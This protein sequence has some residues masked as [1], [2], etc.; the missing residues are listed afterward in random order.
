MANVV[1]SSISS[2]M[3]AGTNCE[4]ISAGGA[5]KE[6]TEPRGRGT[7]YCIVCASIGMLT[8]GTGTRRPEPEDVF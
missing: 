6:A 2:G 4:A 7:D 1:V 3:G 5:N 8:S